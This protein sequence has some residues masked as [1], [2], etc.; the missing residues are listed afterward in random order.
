LFFYCKIDALPTEF[1]RKEIKD[2]VLL[3]PSEIPNNRIAF[4]SVKK[5]LEEF[6]SLN[7]CLGHEA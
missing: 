5:G 1:D 6:S 2:L 4:D 7:F 3:N